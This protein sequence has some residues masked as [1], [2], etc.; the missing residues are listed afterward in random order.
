HAGVDILVGNNECIVL[1][2]NPTADI[3]MHI[4]PMYGQPINVPEAIID[5]YFPESQG[6]AKG[7]EMLYF[8]YLRIR[9]LLRDGLAQEYHVNDV[10]CNTLHAKRYVISGQVQK[11][12]FRRWIRR[13]A[14]KRNLYGYT[15]NL[16]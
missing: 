1:E 9:R 13:E 3:S 6:M 11:V 16:N 15:R 12:G 10:H 5:F 14:L 2:I 8:D 4:F 7:N